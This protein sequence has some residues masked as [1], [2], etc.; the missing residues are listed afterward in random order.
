VP[1]GLPNPSA[2]RLNEAAMN[3]FHLVYLNL[4]SNIQPETNLPKALKL[5]RD[6]GEVQQ[7]SS[8]W[9]SEAVGTTGPNYLNVCVKFKSTFSQAALKEKVVRT[10]ELELGRIRRAD[11]FAPRTIDIDIVI[12]DDRFSNQKSWG[13][14]YVIV[15]L[16]EIYPDYRNPKTRETVSEIAMRLRQEVWL[17]TRPGVLG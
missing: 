13:L 5:L 1:C 7:V 16:A 9:E 3:K 10:I 2:W 17:E 4:G 6:L 8:V 14:A 12:F 15:P 11:K